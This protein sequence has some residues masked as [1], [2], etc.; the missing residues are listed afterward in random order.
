[1]AHQPAASFHPLSVVAT[2]FHKVQQGKHLKVQPA[3][4]NVILLLNGQTIEFCVGPRNDVSHAA[5]PSD[6]PKNETFQGRRIRAAEYAQ[7]VATAT[8]QGA[9]AGD[10][11]GA[12]LRRNRPAAIRIAS[13]KS[14][15]MSTPVRPG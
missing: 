11:P 13:M 12:F 10:L 8:N 7:T 14:G 1:M 15:V 6:C 9:D 4:G 3:C 2:T 5:D